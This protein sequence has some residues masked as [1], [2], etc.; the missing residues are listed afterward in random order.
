MVLGFPGPLRGTHALALGRGDTCRWAAADG[1][2]AREFAPHQ[3]APVPEPGQRLPSPEIGT[4]PHHAQAAPVLELS[5][6]DHITVRVIP[7]D[8]DGFAGA[9]GAMTYA[10]G[11][12]AKLD[13]V[14]AVSL[15]PGRSRDFIHGR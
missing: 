12:V 11:T 13:T 7:F 10:A 8:L 2:G 5:G 6:A 3:L 4:G 9:A 14:E 1:T 15:D